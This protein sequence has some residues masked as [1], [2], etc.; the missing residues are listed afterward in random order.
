MKSSKK[1]IAFAKL[2]LEQHG[3]NVTVLR[4]VLIGFPCNSNKARGYKE[5]T[6]A[7]PK[8]SKHYLPK[9]C[10]CGNRSCQT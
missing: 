8:K 3:P 6:N 1:K 7:F 4:L 10:D 9:R 2:T 5:N